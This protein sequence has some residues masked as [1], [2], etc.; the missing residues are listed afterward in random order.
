[1]HFSGGGSERMYFLMGAS[2]AL[3]MLVVTQVLIPPAYVPQSPF[4]MFVLAIFMASLAFMVVRSSRLLWLRAGMN[5]AALFRE[6]ERHLL[7]AVLA[8]LSVP[9]VVFGSMAL[10]Q[11]TDFAV[12]I[13]LH[14]AAQL[15]FATCF[16][17]AGLAVT[18]GWS[19]GSI[20]LF[21]LLSLG[22]A[23][24]GVVALAALRPNQ[25]HSSWAYV[26][27]LLLFSALALGL[28]SYA[29]HAWLKLDWRLTGPPLPRGNR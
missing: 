7:R 28:R 15:A 6:A 12:G 29:R 2:F 21:T 19:A 20:L 8:T 16:L 17:Y 24:P 13:V 5:R 1:M 27:A 3:V 22:L 23:I 14:F 18:R 4:F 11:R 25:I 26:I 10:T 9:A